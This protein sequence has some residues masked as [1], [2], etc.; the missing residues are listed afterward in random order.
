LLYSLLIPVQDDMMAQLYHSSFWLLLL[1]QTGIFGWLVAGLALAKNANRPGMRIKKEGIK[2]FLGDH[3]VPI[4][5]GLLLLWSVVSCL[6]SSNRGLSFLG[7]GYRR[8]G[9][10]TY[11]MYG[12][13][14]AAARVPKRKQ[15]MDRILVPLVI[16]S[17]LLAG[18]A[19]LAPPGVQ[20][21]FFITPKT[22]VFYNANHYGYY[23]CLTLMCSWLLFMNEKSNAW[24][25]C[26]Y[27]AIF[28]IITAALLQNG[29]LGPYLAIIGGLVMGGI[30]IAWRCR[31]RWVRYIITVA[32]FVGVS[33]IMNELDATLTR[34]FLRLFQDTQN[35]LTSPDQALGAGSGRWNLWINGIALARSRPLFGFGP[36]NLAQAYQ[37]V[38]IS[39]DRPHN[40]WIQIAASLGIP[41]LFF[42]LSAVIAHVVDYFKRKQTVFQLE[43]DLLVVLA[44][45]FIS[46]LFGNTM[47][48]TT[49]FF[50][51]IW[52][53][54]AAYK[55]TP[56]AVLQ[57]NIR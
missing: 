50:F 10:L 24:F 25:R 11:F 51:I 23:L 20:E 27:L 39:L 57:S 21:R 43:S 49:P 31:E 46:S 37:T 4:L 19:L 8:D 52:G 36:D 15:S 6:L 35:V 1:R 26:M 40:E 3:A 29:S 17:A 2:R 56:A 18:L 48:Y 5:L 38:G 44:A 28:S 54:A 47:F 42:Y 55:K 7:D 53:L 30:L 33:V 45:Y 34:D 22:S 41:A 32:C 14:F 9:L 12:G 16:A 13:L